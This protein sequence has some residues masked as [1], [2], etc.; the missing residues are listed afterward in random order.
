[1]WMPGHSGIKGNEYAEK[2]AKNVNQHP[3]FIFPTS[4]KT[5]IIIKIDIYMRTAFE[6]DWTK[7]E[8]WEKYRFSQQ[9]QP[10]FN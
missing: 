9:T 2:A 7:F 10:K 8:Q 4:V 1:M 3:T 6:N 5:D